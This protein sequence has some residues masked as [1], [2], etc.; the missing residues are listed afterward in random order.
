MS[1]SKKGQYD[2]VLSI[3]II[4]LINEDVIEVSDHQMTI[5]NG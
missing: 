3:L 2:V 4:G 1:I 5:E